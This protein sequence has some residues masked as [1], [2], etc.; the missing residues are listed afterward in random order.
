MMLGAN[1][2]RRR[3]VGAGLCASL[4]P[5]SGHAANA[6]PAAGSFDADQWLARTQAAAVSLNYQGTFT[7]SGGGVV[8]SSKVTHFRDARHRYERIEVLDGQPRRQFRQDDEVLTLWL[9][10][11]VAVI[12]S[13]D[14]VPEFP[15]LPAGSQRWQDS[16]EVRWMA[17]DRVAGQEAD[18]VVAKPR[19]GQR[20]AQRLWAERATGLLLRADLLGAKGDL[21]ESSAFTEVMLG[22]RIA[23]DTVTG[24][25]R[26]LDGYKVLRSLSRKVM[27]ESEG[28]SIARTPA[29]FQRVS[30]MRKN[31][32][33]PVGGGDPR[34][35]LQVV[36][37]DGLTHVSVFVEAFD[38]GRHKPMRT[39][40]GATHTSMS[41]QGDWWLTIVGDVPM[42]T[43]AQFESGLQRR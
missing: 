41:R 30:C 24:P 16:Y 21:L 32:H 1:Q 17:Q 6:Q 10:T 14:V 13:D 36:F 35:V 25:M 15:A 7:F 8:S 27:L 38:A 9:Q 4:M 23:A 12:E 31:L 2:S 37:S 29:G 5:G 18:V 40:L 19:D 11:K 20:F 39:N 42:T 34:E 33:D 22:V 28:W 3:L 26:R 43:I